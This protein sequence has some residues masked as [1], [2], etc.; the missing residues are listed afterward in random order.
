MTRTDDFDFPREGFPIPLDP[1]AA[2][3]SREYFSTSPYY[4]HDKHAESIIRTSSWYYKD[5]VL[6]VIYYPPREYAAVSLS[7]ANPFQRPSSNGLGSLDRLPLELLFKIFYSLDMR[8]L[9]KFRQANLISREMIHY[10][11][12]YDKIAVHALNPLCALLRTGLAVHVSLLEFYNA[13]CTKTC[14][15]CK[16]FGGFIC[17]PIWKRCCFECMQDSP[18]TQ[19]QPL[20]AMQEQFSIPESKL[21]RK[22]LRL[23]DYLSGVYTMNETIYDS[24]YRQTL[25]S[26]HQLALVCKRK[27]TPPK[28]QSIRKH[29]PEPYN[30]MGACALPYYDKS[31]GEVDSGLRCAGCLIARRY[32]IISR[33][34][35]ELEYGVSSEKAFTRAD[36]L[37]HFRWCAC[38]QYLW[39]TSDEGR[40][41]P[42]DLLWTARLGGV[43]QRKRD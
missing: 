3:R 38:A 26:L 19:L 15:F 30:F 5:P 23:F 40:Q 33:S 25:V 8:S 36:Y 18:E 41:V 32:E 9:L 14:S 24:K 16:E 37:D 21:E 39:E 11:T 4:F 27:S 17:L 2:L 6:A 22:Q 42:D 10:L 28:D 29:P 34:R 12:Q 13:L 31:T 1:A 43:F 20:Y 35:M 7:L